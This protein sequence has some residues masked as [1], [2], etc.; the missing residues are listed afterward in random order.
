[1]FVCVGELKLSNEDVIKKGTFRSYSKI[2]LRV[3][4]EEMKVLYEEYLKNNLICLL[5][6][7]ICSY[8]EMCKVKQEV[9]QQQPKIRHY[10]KISCNKDITN[11]NTE[12]RLTNIR[13]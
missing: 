9:K 2:F 5:Q 11:R 13:I 7:F 8:R 3:I 1:M 6:K 12:Q 4:K 10:E